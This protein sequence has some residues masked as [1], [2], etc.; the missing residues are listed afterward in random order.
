[1]GFLTRDHVP[2]IHGVLV[3]DEAKTTHELDLRDLARTVGV[4]VLFDLLLG[5]WR[6]RKR[7]A[8]SVS[9]RGQNDPE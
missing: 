1:M 7:K 5:D 3:F 9:C 2:S 6:M 8:L 4:E